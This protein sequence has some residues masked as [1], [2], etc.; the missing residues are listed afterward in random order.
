VNGT[1]PISIL[2][3]FCSPRKLEYKFSGGLLLFP[4]VWWA[5]AT[6]GV[7]SEFVQL[8]LIPASILWFPVL[9]KA[10]ELFKD[11]LSD[12]G[13]WAWVSGGI[14]VSESGSVSESAEYQC[15]SGNSKNY[16]HFLILKKFQKITCTK[17]YNKWRMCWTK[18]NWINKY[19]QQGSINPVQSPELIFF[20]TIS[21]PPH[22]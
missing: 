10:S 4:Q 9:S 16:N 14:T 2:D 21:K 13:G 8:L 17:D 22:S 3:P 20:C 15:S 5:L 1:Y 6:F 7:E 12:W 19:Y 18:S 11:A